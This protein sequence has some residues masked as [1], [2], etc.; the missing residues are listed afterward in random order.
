MPATTDTPAYW[1]VLLN[2]NGTWEFLAIYEER[3]TAES[4]ARSCYF[5][6]SALAIVANAATLAGLVLAVTPKP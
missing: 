4:A 5:N 6:T 1:T 2:R 3:E